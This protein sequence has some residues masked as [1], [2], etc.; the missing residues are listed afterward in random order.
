MGKTLA[1]AVNAQPGPDSLAYWLAPFEGYW[2]RYKAENADSLNQ[3]TRGREQ[4]N[5]ANPW[6]I[7]NLL[8]GPARYIASPMTALLPTSEEIYNSQLEEWAK[9]ALAGT[10]M[11][12]G[13]V[14]PGPK[15][16]GLGK[17]LDELTDA[18]TDA[19][20]A[21][22]GSRLEAEAVQ[23]GGQASTVTRDQALR[24][25]TEAQEAKPKKGFA[26]Q[27]YQETLPDGTTKW[28]PGTLRVN[29]P[30][31][32]FESEM[33]PAYM[34]KLGLDPNKK[35][36]PPKGMNSTAYKETYEDGTIGWVPGLMRVKR[37]PK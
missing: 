9:P 30:K 27:S 1:D 17:G 37:P 4:I 23:T 10:A 32:V 18:A 25:L 13:F 22:L 11:A 31:K 19:E 34:R 7:G 29:P 16:K 2:D 24:N 12:A 21:A 26:T 28:L 15:V 35:Y 33:S 36:T 3:I 6:G 8:M 14:M 20:R 5:N